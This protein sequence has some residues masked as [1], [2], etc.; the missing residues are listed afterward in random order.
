MRFL[1]RM[2]AIGEK[3][4]RSLIRLLFKTIF[5]RASRDFKPLTYASLAA[6]RAPLPAD[7][8]ADRIFK[9][10]TGDSACMVARLGSVELGTVIKYKNMITKPPLERLYDYGLR[11]EKSWWSKRGAD[12]LNINAGFFPI[13]AKNLDRFSALML[14]SM[15]S[16]DLL[17]SWVPGENLFAQELKD[18]EV[19]ALRD[20]EPYYHAR[21][22]TRGLEN[23][24]VL[25]IHP[26]A[27][28]ILHQY[29][30]KRK[31]LFK[32]PGVLPEFELLA[33]KAVQS[34]AGNLTS[35]PDWFDA[36]DFMF[37]ESTK[38]DFDVAIIGCGA[39]GFP[40]AAKIKKSGRKAIHLGGATQILFG[41]KGKR[42]DQHPVI[43]QLYN[44]HWI[45]PSRAE[46]P[47]RTDKV[48]DSC[49]W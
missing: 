31:L 36:L 1:K 15:S 14:D 46:T 38:M 34:I 40:L 48:E 47:L 3:V 5:H 22:W 4:V 16:V 37:E 9:L 7:A 43:S 20:V 6:S 33:I 32:N 2:A 44:E 21:P 25:V 18:A 27:E 42:W 8:A 19:C 13:S 28:S 24:R 29:R 35:F 10:V 41:I 49:Y 39:Y 17:G 45:R 12:E 11:G 30:N 26:F 23:K